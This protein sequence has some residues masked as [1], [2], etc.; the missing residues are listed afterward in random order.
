MVP[1][2]F[3]ISCVILTRLTT[4][5]L[6][7]LCISSWASTSTKASGALLPKPP[8]RPPGAVA[9]TV[10]AAGVVAAAAGAVVA[11]AGAL[12]KEKPVAA[13]AG[14]GAL[15]GAVAGAPKGLAAGAAAPKERAG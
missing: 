4:G 5:V 6:T 2:R 3:I 10:A 13:G 7:A 14:A 15:K 9:V 12:P 8:A 1:C 11:A